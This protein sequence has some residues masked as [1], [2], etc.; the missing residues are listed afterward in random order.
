VIR[1]WG[2]GISGLIPGLE[3]DRPMA[4]YASSRL[5]W[6][7]LLCVLWHAAVPMV[8]AAAGRQQLV[9][10]LCSHQGT[11]SVPLGPLDGGAHVLAALQCPLCLAGAHAAALPPPP[12]DPARTVLLDCGPAYH[13]DFSAWTFPLPPY[14]HFSSRAPP[15]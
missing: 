12:S 9:A 15:A 13:V 3:Y 10:E 8:H 7:A 2:G 5:A 6:L 4:A 1:P 14:L 11:A